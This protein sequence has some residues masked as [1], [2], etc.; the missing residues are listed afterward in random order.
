MEFRYLVG[1][2]LTLIDLRTNGRIN[3]QVSPTMT[4]EEVTHIL[5]EQGIVQPG[6]TVAYGKITEDGKFL[7]LTTSVVEDLL[8]LQRNGQ[9]VAIMVNRI[10]GDKCID[11]LRKAGSRF[12]FR[13]N[14]DLIYGTF[15]WSGDNQQVYFV[16]VRCQQGEKPPIIHICPYPRY[17]KIYPRFMDNHASSCCWEARVGDDLCCFWHI[18]EVQFDDL[19]KLYKN[20]LSN[21]YVHTLN[22]LFQILELYRVY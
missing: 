14:R 9:S 12:G 10:N 3:V 5:R 21:V 8:A 18:D 16:Y 22:S 4:L 1:N 15:K 20:D 19:L 7:P 2:Q 11:A 6:E 17:V 13:Y